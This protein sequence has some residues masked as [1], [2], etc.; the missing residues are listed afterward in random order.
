MFWMNSEALAME[1]SVTK[2]KYITRRPI[3]KKIAK[4]IKLPVMIG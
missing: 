3:E 1:K 2:V 4:E